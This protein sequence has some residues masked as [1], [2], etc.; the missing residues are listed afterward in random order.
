MSTSALDPVQSARFR[1][2]GPR[3]IDEI[4]ARYGLS[5]EIRQAVRRLSLVLPFRVND[6]VLSQL[7]DWRDIPEDPIFQMVFPQRGMLA[8]DDER[9]LAK[10]LDEAASKARIAEVVRGIRA[11]LNPHP[12]GQKELNVPH[13]DGVPLPGLQH[14]YRETV[15]YFPANGQSCHA[16]CTYC[17]RWAQF[18]GDADL[19]FAA[20]GPNQLIAYLRRHQEVS[21]VLVT[22]GDPMVMS[23]ARLRDHIMPLLGVDS[24]RTLRIGTKSLAYWPQR[25]ITDKDADDVL[26][27]FEDVV[28]SGRNLAVMAHFSHPRELDTDLVRQALSRIRSTGALVY[29][30]APLIAHVN[31]DARTWTRLW[32]AELATGIVPYY[33]FVERDTGPHEYFK[34]PLA[35]ALDIFRNAYVDLPGLARTVRGP[36]MSATAGKVVVDGIEH[37]ERGAYF[38]LRLLQARDPSLVGRPFRA[39]Y[40]SIASWLDQL[41]LEVG[42]SADIA[43][44]LLRATEPGVSNQRRI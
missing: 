13:L 1:A 17:F 42:T 18:V 24:I 3:Q 36:V 33:L 22:G 20:P 34:V 43:A 44:A 11:R 32:R 23:T 6:Y 12:S 2:H 19:R 41:R 15:L 14:K 5:E 7:V 26:R 25:F 29:G 40:S 8:D 35:R 16:Y 39:H 31:D 4:A 37:S 30:Q 10:L 28:A 9:Q 27:L 21:D 38:Q